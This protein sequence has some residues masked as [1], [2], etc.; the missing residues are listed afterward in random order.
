MQEAV[1]A[2]GAENVKELSSHSA[3]FFYKTEIVLKK[4]ILD[5][6]FTILAD[7]LCN[8]LSLDMII[9][10]FIVIYYIFGNVVIIS[11]VLC[12]TFSNC[13]LF[14]FHYFAK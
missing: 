1:H 3:Q 5:L 10:S 7:I 12:F 6:P 11:Y 2:A 8:L 14:P 13:L 4:T 9:K